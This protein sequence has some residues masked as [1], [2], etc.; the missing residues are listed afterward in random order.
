M[1]EQ[2]ETGTLSLDE[3]DELDLV[4]QVNLLGM[5]WDRSFRHIGGTEDTL[6]EFCVIASSVSRPRA[7]SIG[8]A[9][10]I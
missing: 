2:A 6:V 8:C 3:V 1:L 5:L 9:I 10:L 7:G 4:M